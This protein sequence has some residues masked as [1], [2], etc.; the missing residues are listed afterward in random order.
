MAKSVRFKGSKAD[1]LRRIREIVKEVS[2]SSSATSDA[3]VVTEVVSF[4]L[5]QKVKAE[6]IVKARGGSDEAGITWLKLSKAYLAYGRR[7]GRGEQAALKKGAGLGKGN[8]F[9]PGG[10]T[11][12]LTADQYRRWK[13]IF[14]ITFIKM[15]WHGK[16]D[17][18][19][20]SIA[21]AVA[22]KKLK[23]AGAKTKLEVYGN[24]EVEMMRDTG[25]LLGSLNHDPLPGAVRIRF[26]APYAVPA[27]SRRPAW[28][29]GDTEIPDG[30]K[31]VVKESLRT[32]LSAIIAKRLRS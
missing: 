4:A 13:K 3:Q 19:A 25:N 23:E 2:N 21:A 28:P 24:R 8:R 15:K 11:G 1:A 17:G 30:W 29:I 12:L 27:L 22:W 9:A 14:W 32:A 10:K 7:F 16:S 5:I 18:E 6:F 20:K 26:F 31:L